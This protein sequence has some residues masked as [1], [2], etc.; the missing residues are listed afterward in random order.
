[1]IVVTRLNRTRFALNPDLIER[2]Q[3]SPDTTIIMVDAATFVVTETMAEV[4][5]KITE[6]RAGVLAAAANLARI[7]ISPADEPEAVR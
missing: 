6:Y 3:A 1:M 4:I 2:I 7:P 5:A